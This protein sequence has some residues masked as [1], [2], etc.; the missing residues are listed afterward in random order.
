MVKFVLLISLLWAPSLFAQDISV[1]M[2]SEEVLDSLIRN[3]EKH[4]YS[5]WDSAF[6]YLTKADSLAQQLQKKIK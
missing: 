1:K 6:L 5:H 3:S 4:L 2:A